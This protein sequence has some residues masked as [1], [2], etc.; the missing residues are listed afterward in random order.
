MKNAL[1][2]FL[3]L[4]LIVAHGFIQTLFVAVFTGLAFIVLFNIIDKPKWIDKLLS[5][6]SIHS[7]NMWLTHMFFYMIYFKDLIYAPKYPI[8][9]FIWLVL[10]N[11]G[12]SYIINVIYNPIIKLLDNKFNYNKQV[13]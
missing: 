3:I 5:F 13:A 12:V 4:L 9:I 2:I 8:L 11:I 7:T 1:S 10:L 6:I